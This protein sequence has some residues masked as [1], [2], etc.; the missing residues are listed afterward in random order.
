MKTAG[1]PTVE[2]RKARFNYEIIESLEV[3]I[4]LSGTEVKSI[5]NGVVGLREAYAKIRGNEIFSYGIAH[6]I[7]QARQFSQIMSRA[8]SVSSYC[9]E[10]RLHISRN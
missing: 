10:S 9:I 1:A 4:A 8:A 5:R 6:S 2:N 7:I 3:G